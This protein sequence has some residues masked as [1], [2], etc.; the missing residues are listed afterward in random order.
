M[1]F[2]SRY[3]TVQK[4]ADGYPKTDTVSVKWIKKT[5]EVV[6]KNGS[7]LFRLPSASYHKVSVKP[8]A[9]GAIDLVGTTGEIDTVL[10]SFGSFKAANS[11]ID[12]FSAVSTGIGGGIQWWRWVFGIAAVY[13]ALNVV[14]GIAQT[15]RLAALSASS[16]ATGRGAPQTAP[17]LVQPAPSG[18]NNFNPNE[19]SLEEVERLAN[20][21]QY[22]FKPKIAVPQIRAPELS[23]APKE[24]K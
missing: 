13:F 3:R 17:G 16:L 2:F 9:N 19:P 21:G 8:G 5:G 7:N 12:R 22:Q 18:A 6:I 4:R 20:G 11:A 15:G 24:A 1:N 10:A 23:C 14:F